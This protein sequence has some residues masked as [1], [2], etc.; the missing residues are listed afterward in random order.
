MMMTISPIAMTIL[1]FQLRWYSLAYIAA[2]IFAYYRGEVLASTYLDLNRARWRYIV[3]LIFVYGIIGGRVGHGVFYDLS[4]W[5]SHPFEIFYLWH[6]GMSF[7][8]AMM[9]A[10]F[11]LWVCH[12]RFH[13]SMLSLSDIVCSLVPVGLG[14]GRLA[15]MVNSECL[16]KVTGSDWG[17]VF[18]LVDM[19][20]RYPTQM[21]EALFEG[22]FLYILMSWTP[23]R[24]HGLR[25]G[26][27]F[28][29]YGLIR[30]CIEPYKELESVWV[31]L[32]SR[33]DPSVVLS[34]LSM[35]VGSI[36]LIRLYR[37]QIQGR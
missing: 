15:N 6:G 36:L 30:F 27:F 35:I 5:L 2:A 29:T 19:S 9:G 24:H 7:F 3:E 23:M 11:G 10:F 1:G 20:H 32:G 21:V 12:R 4:F 14:L 22:V 33:Y 13:C 8:G 16:G 26:L 18:P 31:M 17:M 28:L 25:S 37:S 34:G